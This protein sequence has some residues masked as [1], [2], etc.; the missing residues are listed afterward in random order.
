MNS[1]RHRRLTCRIVGVLLLALLTAQWSVLGHA[2]AHGTVAP[3]VSASPAAHG[4][5]DLELTWG[6]EAGAAECRLFDQLLSGQAVGAQAAPM[7][8]LPAASTPVV[9]IQL[10]P[11]RQPALRSYLARGPPQARAFT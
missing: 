7:P 10:S 3:W 9:A 8:G 4:G 11:C 2:I 1:I 6:H 5:N